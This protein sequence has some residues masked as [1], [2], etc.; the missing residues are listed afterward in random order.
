MPYA[1]T[2]TRTPFMTKTKKLDMQQPQFSSNKK[3]QRQEDIEEV[4]E[5]L[6]ATETNFRFQKS[7][8]TLEKSSPYLRKDLSPMRLPDISSNLMKLDS[9]KTTSIPP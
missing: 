9:R 5:N 4:S 3:L 6:E 1:T 8:T 7:S 2:N